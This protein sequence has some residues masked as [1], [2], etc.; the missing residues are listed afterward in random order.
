MRFFPFVAGLLFNLTPA[1]HN[2]PSKRRAFGLLH[3]GQQAIDYE[4]HDDFG[5]KS[6]LPEN[7]FGSLKG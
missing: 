6:G 3:A 4:A 5:S 1:L 7:R 2:P